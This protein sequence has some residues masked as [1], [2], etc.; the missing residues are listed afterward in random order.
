MHSSTP[1]TPAD[2]P[3]G[4]QVEVTDTQRV[5]A[6][7]DPSRLAGLVRRTLE[8]E[9]IYDAEISL[10]I[11]D[12]ARIRQINREHLDHDWETDVITFPLSAESDDSLSGELVVSAE[13][14]QTTARAIGIA[15]WN[16]LSLYVI[17]GLLHLIGFDDLT[18]E[19]A[20]AM[21]SR[22]SFHLA[23]EGLENPFALG[24]ALV[25]PTGKE[26]EPCRS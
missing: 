15:T 18:E 2:F 25:T 9:N 21:R 26:G 5:V 1:P 4:I 8:R 7:I 24:A 3:S 12:D 20:A 17:H 23:A 10:F 11:V 14:A 19:A 22:E 6:S 13:T 16:E